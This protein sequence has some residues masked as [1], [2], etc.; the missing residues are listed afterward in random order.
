MF[1]HNLTFFVLAKLKLYK[2]QFRPYIYGLQDSAQVQ[3]TVDRI[4]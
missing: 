1:L 2:D 4:S 3:S